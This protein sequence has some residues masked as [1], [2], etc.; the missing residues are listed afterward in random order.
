MSAQ[1]T[2]IHPSPLQI[3]QN[4]H[5]ISHE[6]AYE[7]ARALLN[8]LTSM[9]QS[10]D[11]NI[12]EVCPVLFDLWDHLKVMD[13]AYENLEDELRQARGQAH[14]EELQKQN[15]VHT[16]G[17]MRR[18]LEEKISKEFPGLENKGLLGFNTD[19]AQSKRA[20][21]SHT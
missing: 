17:C 21:N 3:K 1:Y 8:A 5:G 6:D 13:A 15:D 14:G 18:H 11:T 16:V 20:E 12:S 2:G 10:I 9:D 7:R 4:L 19:C